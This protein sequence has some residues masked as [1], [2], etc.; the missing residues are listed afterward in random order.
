M[1]FVLKTTYPIMPACA[2]IRQE[3]WRVCRHSP[4]RVARTRQTCQH[5][6][7]HLLSTRQTRRHLPEAIFEKNVTRLAK[8][9]L[10]IRDSRKFGASGHCLNKTQNRGT[11]QAIF[12]KSLDF[13]EN[14]RDPVPWVFN[15]CA[16]MFTNK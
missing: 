12:H 14:F 8:F 5:S 1:L 13:G 4:S 11:P 10:V 3:A 16:S 2:N 9:A 7:N 15:P 6:P